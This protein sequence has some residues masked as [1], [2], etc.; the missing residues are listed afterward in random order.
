[1][2]E[3]APSTPPRLT[4]DLS[5]PRLRSASF[6]DVA[7]LPELIPPPPPPKTKNSRNNLFDQDWAPVTPNIRTRSST[8]D[9][10]SSVESAPSPASSGRR[11]WMDRR[12]DVVIVR[13]SP[14]YGPNPIAER[15]PH[16]PVT[17]PSSSKTFSFGKF[18]SAPAHSP[19]LPIVTFP[20]SPTS[21]SQST[22]SPRP[23][24]TPSTSTSSILPPTAGH[25]DNP[26]LDTRQA[27]TLRFSPT[28]N[29][30]LG[31]G[32]H[33]S[34][35]LASF[36]PRSP[37]CPSSSDEVRPRQLCA[38]KRLFPDRESQLSGLGEAFIISK[39]V[40]PVRPSPPSPQ[41]SSPYPQSPS[42]DLGN[43]GSRHI[44]QL[45]GVKDERDGLEAPARALARADSKKSTKRYSAGTTLPKSPLRGE[46]GAP[47]DPRTGL[48]TV[49]TAP[50]ADRI[51][52]APEFSRKAH[53]SQG[54]VT[55]A[56][57]RPANVAR[58]SLLSS[59]AP[60]LSSSSSHR[61]K[62][63]SEAGPSTSSVPGLAPSPILTT[64]SD[65]TLNFPSAGGEPRIDLVLEFCPFGNLL[66][67]ARNHPERMSR[68]LWF[69]WSREIVSAV[70]WCHERGV[71]HA[72]IKPQ[73]IMIASDVSTRLCDFGMSLFL[74]PASSPRAAFPTDP[75][76]LG[77]PNYSPPEFVR[78]L[79]STFSY[80][81]DIFSLGTTLGVMISGREPYE[82]VRAIER[83][84]LVGSGA[85]WEWEENKRL[86]EMDGAELEVEE[87]TSLYNLSLG[88]A[89]QLSRQASLR[90]MRSDKGSLKR[91][92]RRSGSSESLRSLASLSAGRDWEAIADT[93]LA[94]ATEDDQHIEASKRTSHLSVFNLPALATSTPP[95]PTDSQPPS[96]ISSNASFC[97]VRHYPGTSTPVQTFLDGTSHVPLEVR[98]LLKKMTNP[99]EQARPT[100]IEVLDELDR[101][102]AIY[103]D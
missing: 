2:G 27:P 32:R 86:K 60:P 77:T 4:L 78:P 25:S 30:L 21:P 103:D 88:G 48:A 94:T 51:H 40:A 96:L 91:S 7:P 69:Q 61:N 72:D 47:A 95:S 79:P 23:P 81:S 6:F 76:G 63:Q 57:S 92:V 85:W 41:S 90:S 102:A 10:Q 19:P 12:D 35:Y 9:S 37:S 36:R 58:K 14:T 1:M 100:A 56:P 84:L 93:L 31:E 66:Q 97:S 50:T 39:L 87:G 75:H 52:P 68:S 70:A 53:V 43:R 44:L 71:L 46:P 3:H 54:A 65:P 16:W 22:F 18:R 45:Y 17:P 101:L 29:Y 74:P 89:G 73:N 11:S 42:D 15:A 55:T 62:S 33:A 83:M 24:L 49:S 28:S 38:A 99:K 34:V 98:E 82:G 59:L 80:P 67:F 20:P 8:A 13:G 64:S 26:L 5:S